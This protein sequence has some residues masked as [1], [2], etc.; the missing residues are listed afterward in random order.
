[1]EPSIASTEIVTLEKSSVREVV[2]AVKVSL[3]MPP[4]GAVPDG[5]VPP[6][7]ELSPEGA[8]PDGIA[9]GVEPVLPDCELSVEEPESDGAEPDGAEP[10]D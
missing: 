2:P 4:E 5:V 8:V 1:V 9:G 3:V 6:D 7:W 10:P